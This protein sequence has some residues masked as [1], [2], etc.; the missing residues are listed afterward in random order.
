MLLDEDGRAVGTAAKRAVHGADTPLHLAFS[1]YVFDDGGAAARHPPRAAQ[2]DLPRRVDQQRAAA[3][4]RPASRSRTP[5]AAGGVR[6]SASS[7]TT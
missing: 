6:S 5:Y 3:T 7:S 4:R 1:C 2:A